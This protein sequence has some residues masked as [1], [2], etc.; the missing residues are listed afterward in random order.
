VR[1]YV[2]H[3]GGDPERYGET[4][5]PHLFPQWSFPV[6]TR[7]LYGVSYPLL[8]IVNAGCRLEVR[9]PLY[10]SEPLEVR[11]RLESIEED[12]RRA[13][14]RQKIV[15]RNAGG[16]DAVLADLFAIVPLRR[17]RDKKN[18][19]GG[20]SSRGR[21]NEPT[22]PDA[23]REIARW[24]LDANA[25]LAFALLTGDFNP[26]HWV[27]PYARALG[28]RSTI[29][30]GFATMARAIE[31]IQREL[32]AGAVDRVRV[33]DVRFT[34]PLYLPADVGLFVHGEQVFV[35][36]GVGGRAYLTGSMETVGA[37][38]ERAPE[39]GDPPRAVARGENTRENLR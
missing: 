26:L 29:L 39:S 28:F 30:H 33:W 5:P 36:D 35:A 19:L 37:V 13:L 22:V 6:A 12:E 9:A 17:G 10:A 8:Q 31:G 25:G 38:A 1:D 24:R 34:R 16:P 20:E 14:L 4:L 23:A 15:T 18:G 11:A 27:R 2:R 3:L 32:F 21:Q 7:T